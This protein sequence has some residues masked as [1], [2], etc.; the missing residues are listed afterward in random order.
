[1]RALVTG[2]TG[3]IGYH[4][5]RYLHQKGFSV[6]ALARNESDTTF[7][8]DFCE[9]NSGDVRDLKSL[10]LAMKDC[11]HVYHVAADYRYWVPDIETMYAINVE[12]TMNVMR[13]ALSSSSV[14]K[15]VYTSTA[16]VIAPGTSNK[17]S[18]E[19]NSAD[20]QDMVNHY[21]KSKYLAEKAVNTF[22]EKGLPIVIVNPTTTIGPCD[23]R[24]TPSGQIIVDF[25]NGKIPAYIDTGLNI[26]DV[27]DVAAGHVTAAERGRVG[28]RY[29]LGNRNITLKEF[30]EYLAK[31]A[32]Q[33]A[34]KVRLPYF[35]VVVTAY[36]SEAL[37]KWVTHNQPRVS[38]SSVKMAKNYMYFDNSKAVKELQM[39]QS[40][41]ETTIEKAIRWYRDNG[42]VRS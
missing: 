39:P 40:S 13:A 33:R 3:F 7:L 15:I 31:A 29:I 34:P 4:V 19:E 30:F 22:I 9:L 1:M 37:S 5:A 16:G 36:V 10:S 17:P 25:L 20:F 28:Q 14:E 11:K 32:E 24:P 8:Q 38:L 21:K 2:A 42:Y 23:R 41:I 18:N 12:G 27:E 26:V 6:R 35:P